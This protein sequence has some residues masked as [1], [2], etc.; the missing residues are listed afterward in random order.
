MYTKKLNYYYIIY[1][2]T[3]IIN[4]DNIII[5]N[6]VICNLHSGVRICSTKF[7]NKNLNISVNEL[8]KYTTGN[9]LNDNK[10][11]SKLADGKITYE[12][13]FTFFI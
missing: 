13:L 12:Q 11:I 5:D 7:A 6:C 4:M 8:Q 2:V 3:I 10:L 9:R 1:I